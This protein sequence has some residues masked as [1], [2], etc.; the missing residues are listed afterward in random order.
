MPT[1]LVMPLVII[2]LFDCKTIR[3]LVPIEEPAPPLKLIL[4]TVPAAPVNRYPYIISAV[5]EKPLPPSL[6]YPKVGSTNTG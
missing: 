5:V 3:H 6:V 2:F 1:K 4:V